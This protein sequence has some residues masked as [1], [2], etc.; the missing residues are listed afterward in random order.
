M[1][2][3]EARKATSKAYTPYSNFKVGCSVLLDNGEMVSGGNQE[4]ASYPACI[5]AENVAL[6]AAV[7]QFP[8]VGIKALAIA[9]SGGAD[10]ESPVAPCGICRQSILEHQGRSGHPIQILLV[11]GD[12]TIIKANGIKPLL[13]LSF[14]QKDLLK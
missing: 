8:G 12:G 9:T 13:P 4:N 5:C 3:E 2:V 11:G 7:S 6:S 1:L 10:E 14:S